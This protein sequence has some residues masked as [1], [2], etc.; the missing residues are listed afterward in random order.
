MKNTKDIL[1]KMV[2]KKYELNG[3]LVNFYDPPVWRLYDLDEP[4]IYG[5][6]TMNIRYTN[7]SQCTFLITKIST[8]RITGWTDAFGADVEIRI[9]LANLTEIV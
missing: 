6:Y 3:R 7:D 5:Y 1:K 8:T 9:E 2:G 4:P